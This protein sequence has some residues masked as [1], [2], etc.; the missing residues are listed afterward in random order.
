MGALE[1]FMLEFEREMINTRKSLER[2]PEDNL[3]WKPHEKSMTFRGLATHLINLA[4][5]IVFVVE[6]ENFDMAPVGETPPRQDP[7]ESL[8]AAL[9]S[10]DLNMAKA[11]A[12]LENVTDKHLEA[13]WRLLAGGDEVFTMPRMDVLRSMVMSHMIHHRAQL[14]VYLRLNHIAM[15]DLYGPTADE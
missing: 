7:V 4:N 14:G 10:F 11:G 15:P 6:Y 13:P 12:C 9:T 3:D 5:W 1:T 8:E 2:I